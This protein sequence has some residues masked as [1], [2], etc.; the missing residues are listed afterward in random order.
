MENPR[1]FDPQKR[2]ILP[3]DLVDKVLQARS[4]GYSAGY[5]ISKEE[6]AF[7]NIFDFKPADE[8]SSFIMQTLICKQST[9]RK[10][11]G[12]TKILDD[13]AIIP[14]GTTTHVPTSAVK[15]TLRKNAINSLGLVKC[16]MIINGINVQSYSTEAPY[17]NMHSWDSSENIQ[18]ELPLGEKSEIIDTKQRFNGLYNTSKYRL[19]NLRQTLSPQIIT[20][21]GNYLLNTQQPQNSRLV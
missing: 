11:E 20:R 21:L 15:D 13:V 5:L 19:A 4:Q 9:R 7:Y 1:T 14:Y 2:I 8:E 16:Y 3:T 18:T 6:P 12:L 10:K 17:D